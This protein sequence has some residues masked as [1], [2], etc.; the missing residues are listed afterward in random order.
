MASIV[1]VDGKRMPKNF[2]SIS[3]HNYKEL[4]CYWCNK[5]LLEPRYCYARRLACEECWPDNNNPDS[6]SD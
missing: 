5:Q 1:F 3:K 6:D 4:Q 2:F